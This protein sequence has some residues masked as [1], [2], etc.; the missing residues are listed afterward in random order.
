M[1]LQSSLRM[2]AAPSFPDGVRPELRH[3]EAVVRRMLR[4]GSRHGDPIRN[5]IQQA[6]NVVGTALHQ[7]ESTRS[8]A[9]ADQNS[10]PVRDRSALAARLA[11]RI[12][13]QIY[14]PR[15]SRHRTT[16]CR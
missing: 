2:V 14:R 7:T 15:V 8:D 6:A 11:R 3:A 9:A 5:R 4:A 13:H 10:R 12:L 16:D 1:F